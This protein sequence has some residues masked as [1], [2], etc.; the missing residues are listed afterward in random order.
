MDIVIAIGDKA[1]RLLICLLFIAIGATLWCYIRFCNNNFGCC[2]D[3]FTR[4]G[5]ISNLFANFFIFFYCCF[6]YC[7]CCYCCCSCIN[8][9]FENHLSVLMYL[10]IKLACLLA[11][12]KMKCLV[13]EILFLNGENFNIYQEKNSLYLF[14]IF[15]II[16]IYIIRLGFTVFLRFFLYCS[17]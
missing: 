10:K 11:F 15:I 4:F 17:L 6:L 7:Y 2:L 1:N 5:L 12:V 16:Y 3:L 8:S 13:Y 9:R 14:F